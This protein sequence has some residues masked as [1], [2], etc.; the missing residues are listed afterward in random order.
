MEMEQ[1]V[2]IRYLVPLLQLAE[3]EV[4]ETLALVR[5]EEAEVEAAGALVPEQAVRVIT[6]EQVVLT[7]GVQEEVEGLLAQQ[8]VE[9]L[10]V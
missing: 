7:Q 6:V 8:G 3:V 1:M 4:E 5:T 10:E 2:I 9:A